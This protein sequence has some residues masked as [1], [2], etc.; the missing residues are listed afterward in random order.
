MIFSDEF[1]AKLESDN[2]V[3]QK[4]LFLSCVHVAQSE[5]RKIDN[6][7]VAFTRPSTWSTE[8][9]RVAATNKREINDNI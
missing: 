7:P 6:A 8:P 4:I 3:V 9:R 1:C 2:A 5:M